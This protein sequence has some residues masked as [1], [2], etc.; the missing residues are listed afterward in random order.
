VSRRV[1]GTRDDA[2]LAL[3]RLRVA[4]HAGQLPQASTS[5]VTV[6]SLLDRYVEE[7]QVG[8]VQLRPKT[9]VTARSAAR[10]MSSTRLTSGKAFGDVTLSALTWREIE[11]LYGEM[12]RR[13]LSAAWVRRCATVLSRALDRGRK[14]GLLPT[15]PAK[16]ADRPKLVRTKPYSPAGTAVR[17]ALATAQETDPEIADFAAIVA[18][19]GMRTSEL[20]GLRWEDVDEEADELH[21]AWAVTD[22]G[23]GIGVVRMQLKRSDWR[24]VPLT[25][26]ALD[27]IR[28][29]R[30]RRVAAS[31]SVRPQA[32][33]FSGP[34]VGSSPLRPDRLSERWLA[35]RGGSAV[36]LL[37]L[38]HYVA[39]TMLDA[40]V[41]YRTVAELLG[42][43]E[44]TLRLHYD[45]RTNVG[46]RQAIAALCQG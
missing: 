43:S 46:K 41:P 22:G 11:E 14:Y 2:E 15:N 17:E 23:P 18:N 12:A 32:Y 19:A 42:N 36:T 5:A 16:D 39:T 7:A 8:R 20:L 21:L 6:G 24:D 40:G 10:A 13:G 1:H 44:A 33:V 31:G 35:A 26:A 9:L 30:E 28:R 27:A 25:P 4:R 34:G 45:G 3:A 38:R 37:A 29:R